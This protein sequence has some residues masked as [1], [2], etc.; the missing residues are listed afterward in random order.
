MIE[1]AK[2]EWK[3]KNMPSESRTA[4]GGS[5]FFPKYSVEPLLKL[6]YAVITDPD[7][8]NFDLEAYLT[9]KSAENT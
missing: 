8:K 2:L 4:G 7:D 1:K 3:K 6:W 5:Q 9:M